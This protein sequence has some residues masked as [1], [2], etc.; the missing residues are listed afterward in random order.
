LICSRSPGGMDADGKV[1]PVLFS[2]VSSNYFAGLGLKPAWAADLWRGDGRT[3]GLKTSSCSAMA[4]GK[5]A[6]TAI[7][8]RRQAGQDDGHS[9]T[10]VGVAPEDF[11]G[12]F[13]GGLQPICFA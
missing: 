13:S 10:V 4:T 3:T 5:S 11:T 1:E 8:H 6:S 9:V 12:L 2:Y 7:L